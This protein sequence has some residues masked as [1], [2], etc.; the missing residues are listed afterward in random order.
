[1]YLVVAVVFYACLVFHCRI[2][3]NNV[4]IIVY[5]VVILIIHRVYMSCLTVY[6]LSMLCK[7]MLIIFIK[8][9]RWCDYA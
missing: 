3:S 4:T 1:M 2:L 9:L 7:V 5:I 8:T 6:H